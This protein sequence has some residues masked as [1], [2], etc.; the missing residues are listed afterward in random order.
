[1]NFNEY[2]KKTA[3]TAI[4]PGQGTQDGLEY[5]LFGL[6]N[7]AGELLGHYKKC[8]RDNNKVLS[9]EIKRSLIKECGDCLWYLSQM[10]AEL[11]DSLDNAATINY[12]KL[13]SRKERNVLHGNGDER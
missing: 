10:A 3:E 1:M 12:E 9:E 11:N 8:I 4:Y 13:K 2:Q 6:A 5:C 7:E